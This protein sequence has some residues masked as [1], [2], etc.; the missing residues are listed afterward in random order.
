M[1]VF[2]PFRVVLTEVLLLSMCVLE[3]YSGS[4]IGFLFVLSL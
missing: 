1:A 2:V 3:P 4:G